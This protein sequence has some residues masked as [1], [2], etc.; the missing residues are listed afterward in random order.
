MARRGDYRHREPKRPK[1]GVKKPK[2][3][4]SILPMPTAVEVIKKE[5]KPKHTEA[6]GPEEE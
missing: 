6:E 1:K 2:S 4:S 5:R 3:V